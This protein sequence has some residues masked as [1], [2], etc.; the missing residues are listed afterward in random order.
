MI[1]QERTSVPPRPEA[2]PPETE[3][4]RPTAPKARRVRLGWAAAALAG[5]AVAVLVARGGRSSS[6]ATAAGKAPGAARPIPVVAATVKKGDVGVYLTGLG[7]VTPLNNVTVR[8]RVDGQLLRVAFREGQ[9]VRQGDLLAEIDPRP[10]QVQLEQAQGQ[11]GKDTA[12]LQNARVLEAFEDVE[13]NLAALRL[14]S[15]ESEE[16]ARAV[17]AAERA[18]TLAQ[19]R[20]QGGITSYLEVVTAQTTAL[21]NERTAVDLQTRRLTAS[22]SLIKALG[23]GW[24]DM[25]LPEPGAVLAKVTAAPSP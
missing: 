10:F 23:G 25:E 14:L 9:L 4:E 3:P 16:Q 21:A 7:T 1:T 18:L 15:Q 11:L 20:Y 8:T 6:R 5:I 22:L 2:E 19:N 13:D 24:S 12:M 17:A